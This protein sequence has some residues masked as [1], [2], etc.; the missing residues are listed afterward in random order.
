ME[1][2]RYG[3]GSTERTDTDGF[4]RAAKDIKGV[5]CVCLAQPSSAPAPSRRAWRDT[6]TKDPE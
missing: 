5:T 3:V 4:P 6:P 1:E 2:G